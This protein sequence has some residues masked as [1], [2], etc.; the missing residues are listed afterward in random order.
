MLQII[1][2]LFFVLAFLPFLNAFAMD[3]GD[4]RIICHTRNKGMRALEKT[5]VFL[6][7]GEK[8][9]LE[10]VSNSGHQKWTIKR[11]HTGLLGEPYYRIY[12]NIDDTHRYLE[13]FPGQ[14]RIV[15]PMR[16]ANVPDQHWLID[17]IGNGK[18][19]ISCNTQNKGRK[20]LEAFPGD[21]VVRPVDRNYGEIDQEW[22][23]ERIWNPENLDYHFVDYSILLDDFGKP[24]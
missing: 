11:V 17:N 13:A 10:E 3:D 20:Y 1:N 9:S 12:W 23:L 4:Y 7:F 15:K 19:L 18:F 22:R 16:W 6:G 14:D 2:K 24:I 8:V 21:S 5:D